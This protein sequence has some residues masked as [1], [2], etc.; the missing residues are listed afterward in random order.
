MPAA[1]PAVPACCSAAAGVWGVMQLQSCADQLLP[2]MYDTIFCRYFQLVQ[3]GSLMLHPRSKAGN[4]L[5]V[6]LSTVPAAAYVGTAANCRLLQGC[7]DSSADLQQRAKEPS[8]LVG[9]R[10]LVLHD[11]RQNCQN[12]HSCTSTQQ[13]THHSEG[14]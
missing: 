5:A 8:A 13:H 11:Q 2:C 4:L 1:A 12:L 6:P 9:I 7:P 10:G 14:P 3:Q